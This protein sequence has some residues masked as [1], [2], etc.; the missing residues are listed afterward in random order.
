MC[1][2]CPGLDEPDKGCSEG[3]YQANRANPEPKSH[4]QPH[5]KQRQPA[6]SLKGA[7]YDKPGEARRGHDD[8]G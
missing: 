2:R 3:D 7:D 5:I 1:R 6:E 4:Q 8:G